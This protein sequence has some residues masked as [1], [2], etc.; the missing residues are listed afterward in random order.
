[1]RLRELRNAKNKTQEELGAE[2]NIAAS[3]IGMYEQGRRYP[4]IDV[5]R[6]IADYFHVS[7]DYILG[8]TESP[9]QTIPLGEYLRMA[10]QHVAYSPEYVEALTGIQADTLISW[11]MN[12]SR[13]S[14]AELK[15]LAKVYHV[16][17]DV[18]T[19]TD[20]FL[21]S[22]KIRPILSAEESLA[23]ELFETQKAAKVYPIKNTFRVPIIG[24]VRCGAGR[25]AYEDIDEYISIDDTY[26]P[27]DMRGFHAEGDSMEPEIHDGDICLV[28]LQEDV[29]NNALAVVAICDGADECEGTIKRVHKADGTIILQATNPAYPPR[30]FTGENANKVRIVGRVVEVRHKTI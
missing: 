4:S 20:T 23:S 25:C 6:R 12:K 22:R 9:S 15:T 29:P 26:R 11:E 3:T 1:M 2:L 18:L 30:I 19:G 24:V 8:R 17:V 13:P 14:D 16:S 28:H 5:L 27:E 10:R 21:D 7:T